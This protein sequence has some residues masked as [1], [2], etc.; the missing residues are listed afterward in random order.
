MKNALL[1]CRVLV[2]EDNFLICESLCA[3]LIDCGC[4]V[5][6]PAARVDAAL[7]LCESA[8]IDGAFLDINLGHETSLPSPIDYVSKEYLSFSSPATEI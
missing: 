4:E 8:R 5:I 6:G 2:V 3:F 1:G 7:S